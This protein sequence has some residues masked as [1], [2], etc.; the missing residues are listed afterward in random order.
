MS[1]Q[2][3]LNDNSEIIHPKPLNCQAESQGFR[4][5]CSSLIPVLVAVLPIAVHEYYQSRRWKE[6]R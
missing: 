1:R 4:I 2:L 3:K 5:P 6:W